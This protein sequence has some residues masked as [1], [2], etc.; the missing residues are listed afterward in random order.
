MGK[1]ESVIA[2]M[3][4]QRVYLDT[5]IF[6]YFLGQSPEFFEVAAFFIE[7]AESGKI[8]GY[9]GDAA[10]AETL[11]KPYQSDNIGLAASF[12]A[13]FATDDFL[14]VQSHDADTFDLAAQLRGKRG[15]RF[16]DA[17][18]YATALKAGC[19]FFVTNDAGFKSDDAMEVVSI[20]AFKSL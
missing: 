9:T 5:N 14:S 12:K 13:F 1:I 18:H 10:V 6:V 16:V 2:R 20:K 3:A 4:G 15:M 19:K 17:L 7:A 11:V 8:I